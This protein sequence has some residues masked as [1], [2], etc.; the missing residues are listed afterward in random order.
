MPLEKPSDQNTDKLE[1]TV[2]VRSASPLNANIIAPARPGDTQTS[3]RA[4]NT[5]ANPKSSNEAQRSDFDTE[6]LC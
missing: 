1:E 5:R 3:V 6:E 2:A 4:T